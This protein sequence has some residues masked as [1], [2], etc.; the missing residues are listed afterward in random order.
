MDNSVE[1]RGT[2]D[3]GAVDDD[4]LS[5]RLASFGDDNY[6]NYAASKRS[7]KQHYNGRQKQPPRL[8]K[9][10]YIGGPSAVGKSTTMKNI[11]AR[12]SWARVANV[13]FQ[14]LFSL[15]GGDAARAVHHLLHYRSAPM[16]YEHTDECT[17]LY[18]IVHRYMCQRDAGTLTKED[19]H[20]CYRECVN[21]LT[22]QSASTMIIMLDTTKS[23]VQR[24]EH[25]L[26]ADYNGIDY[27]DLRYLYFQVAAYLAFLT[28][29][30]LYPFMNVLIATDNYNCDKST[31]TATATTADSSPSARMFGKPDDYGLIPL[32]HSLIDAKND[33]VADKFDYDTVSRIVADC[34]ISRVDDSLELS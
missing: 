8:L 22:K 26:A 20:S 11:K 33:I 13:N 2:P 24:Y 34:H 7:N 16:I 9:A 15:Y 12:Y 21:A 19:V 5:K 32:L 3:H 6:Y 17:S 29:R 18:R 4:V 25:R 14:N 10:V 28:K 23:F 30:H 1:I 31:T 27:K